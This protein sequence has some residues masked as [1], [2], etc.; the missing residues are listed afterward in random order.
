MSA[1]VKAIVLL[2]VVGAIL[3]VLISPLPEM[4]IAK[5]SRAFLEL[6]QL[7]LVLKPVFGLIA[8]AL[9]CGS[10]AEPESRDDVRAVLCTRLC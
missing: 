3:F 10:R 1:Q 9:L 8:C 2:L 4:A 7:L 5:S 6:T